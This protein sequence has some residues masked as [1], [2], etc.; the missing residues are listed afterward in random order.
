MSGNTYAD[1]TACKCFRHHICVWS[2]LQQKP[3]KKESRCC[4]YFEKEPNLKR[5][6]SFLKVRIPCLPSRKQIYKMEHELPSAY[7]S[8][9]GALHKWSGSWKYSEDYRMSTYATK[10][11]VRTQIATK[12]PELP[13]TSVNPCK[14]EILCT[15]K[16]T[17]HQ[18]SWLH[19]TIVIC[20]QMSSIAI[21]HCR[22]LFFHLTCLFLNVAQT[23]LTCVNFG[24]DYRMY[25][26][27][28]LGDATESEIIRGKIKCC[29]SKKRTVSS[30]RSSVR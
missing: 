9:R 13:R 30:V 22:Y 8:E 5:M 15:H 11:I 1:D 10:S 18:F 16:Y 20:Q 24:P 7:W 4:R 28:I 27:S 3:M 26:L 6:W 25:T 23:C 21:H 2:V 19:C 17:S 12:S 29:E 14:K